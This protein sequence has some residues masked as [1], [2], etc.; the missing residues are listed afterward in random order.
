MK[1]KYIYF[2][3]KVRLARV[4][5][6]SGWGSSR[7]GRRGEEKVPAQGCEGRRAVPLLPSLS[8]LPPP[9]GEGALCPGEAPAGSAGRAG[10]G[11]QP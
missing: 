1:N 6:L 7:A 11:G 5:P 10:P 9:A 3:F 2:L 8:L 4:S